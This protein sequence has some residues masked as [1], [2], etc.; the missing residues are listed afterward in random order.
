MFM[1]FI[2]SHI[3]KGGKLLISGLVEWTF[4]LVI[5]EVSKYGYTLINK[6]QTNEWCTSMLIKSSI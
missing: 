4:D 3:K 6:T 5:N 2:D 1:K